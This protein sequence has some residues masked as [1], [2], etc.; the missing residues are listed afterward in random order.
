M[1]HLL[2]CH[3]RDSALHIQHRTNTYAALCPGKG[4]TKSPIV[5]GKNVKQRKQAGV[6]LQGMFEDMMYVMVTGDNVNEG[7]M[8]S[9]QECQLVSVSSVSFL[10]VHQMSP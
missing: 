7:E 3:C 1:V 4:F 2:H 9:R 8:P 6:I 10:C 5:R